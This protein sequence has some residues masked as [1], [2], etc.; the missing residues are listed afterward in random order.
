MVLR[1]VLLMHLKVISVVCR[2]S[3]KLCRLLKLRAEFKVYTRNCLNFRGTV[4]T[5]WSVSRIE[6]IW[7]CK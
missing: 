5:D 3:V 1:H 7:I 4:H 2:N 6:L